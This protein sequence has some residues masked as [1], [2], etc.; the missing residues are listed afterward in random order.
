MQFNRKYWITN[1]DINSTDILNPNHFYWTLK[2]SGFV[3]LDGSEIN[4]NDGT[5]PLR[6]K[7]DNLT[8][9]QFKFRHNNQVSGLKFYTNYGNDGQGWAFGTDYNSSDYSTYWGFFIPL[10]NQ[11][12][13]II[14]Y[15]LLEC[16]LGT[17][18][19]IPTPPLFNP[20]STSR[21]TTGRTRNDGNVASS[22]ICFYNNIDN[23]FNYINIGVHG[24]DWLGD[25]TG[26]DVKSMYLHN[27][28]TFDLT[29]SLVDSSS[30]GTQ[31][32]VKQN[33]CTMI[34]YPYLNGFLSNLFII[35]TSP[36]KGA[37]Y[38]ANTD[39]RKY[40]YFRDNDANYLDGKFFSFNGRNFYGIYS[41]LA[42]E[43]PAN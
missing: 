8:D 20:T 17:T 13:I 30:A 39:S 28:R 24:L 23:L 18:N 35:T 42:V 14:G 37:I 32:D 7:Y 6:Y 43:L 5:K 15:N 36:N 10:K 41:N 16:V 19:Y 26:P 31:V 2:N 22:L 1:V 33:I 27:G 3:Y 29:N 34:K 12:L 25:Y 9:I 38:K 40:E 21:A 11:G 4:V